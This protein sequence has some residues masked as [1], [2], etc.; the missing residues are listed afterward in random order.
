[1]LAQQ[2]VDLD[3]KLFGAYRRPPTGIL[4]A[5]EQALFLESGLVRQRLSRTGTRV[6]W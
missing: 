4:E 5:L 2:S 1:M 6:W 3:R